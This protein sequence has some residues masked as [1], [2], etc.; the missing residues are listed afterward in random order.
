MQRLVTTPIV[1]LSMLALVIT[2]CGTVTGGAVGAGAGA[3]VA[4]GTGND[5]GKGALIGLG[6]G[7]AAGAIYDIY[8]RN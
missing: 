5:P 4:A 2:G 3:A 8:K 7:A 1:G 6:V